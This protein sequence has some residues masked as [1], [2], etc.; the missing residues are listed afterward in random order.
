MTS[1][2]RYHHNGRIAYGIREEDS[3]RELEGDL[4]SGKPTGNSVTAREVK[5]LVPLTPG[6]ILCVGRNYRSHLETRPAPVKPEVFYK[7]ISCL[8]NPE[9]P[10]VY[11]S[12][13]TDLHYEGELVVVIGKRLRNASVEEAT[14]G[15]FGVTS[16]NDVSEREWQ[17][18]KEKDLQWWRAKGCDTFGPLGPAVVTGLNYSNLRVQTRLNGEVVQDQPTADLMF[19][20]P[21]IVSFISQYLTLEQGDVIFTGTPGITRPMKPGDVVEVEVEGVGVLRSPVVAQ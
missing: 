12:E 9:D 16:G 21:L 18:G 17:A 8:Q 1:Y 5:L 3:I 2:V 11:P 13:A 6:K 4:F 20:C 19:P 14:A 7:P 15:I 10:I